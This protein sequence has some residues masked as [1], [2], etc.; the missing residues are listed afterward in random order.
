MEHY[1]ESKAR[2]FRPFPLDPKSAVA[3]LNVDDNHGR[4][5]AGMTP[6][7][8]V[9][10]S[11]TP[12]GGADV[13][14]EWSKI[15]LDG[16]EA[17]IVVPS[18]RVQIRSL[19]TGRHNLA[20]MLL[21]AGMAHALGMSAE[22]IERGISSLANVPGR[23][24][25]IPNGAGVFC[26]VDYAHTDDALRNVLSTLRELA[27]GRIITV[28]GCGGDRDRGKRPLMGAAAAGLSD[29]VVVTS[30]NPRGEDPA[31]IIAEVV[32]GIAGT[33]KKPVALRELKGT[34]SG[35]AVVQDR[36]EAIAAAAAAS[37]PGD[38]L[39]IA[40]KGHED[41]Q[42]IGASRIHFDDREEAAGALKAPGLHGPRG[43][44]GRC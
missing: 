29:V 10:V 44:G 34:R 9:A 39:I 35:Y 14:P 30:D 31:A 22:A 24:D 43:G 19:L 8:V 5:L 21:A 13:R 20:N 26:F 17:V 28:F 38:V 33:G 12:G 18:G 37:M 40:G 27:S 41:C 36:R 16:I 3:V 7:P 6:F 25:R 15:T 1:F 2:L 11:E 42:I 4:M 32:P 23:L